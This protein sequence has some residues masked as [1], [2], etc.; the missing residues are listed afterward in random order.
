MEL[1][2]ILKIFIYVL[3]DLIPCLV[4]ALIPFQNHFR[5]PGYKTYMLLPLLFSMVFISRILSV[6]ELSVARWFTIL[7]IGLYLTLYIVCIKVPVTI[8]LFTLLTILNYGSFKA[9]IVNWLVHSLP[10]LSAGRYSFF[11]SI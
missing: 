5:F 1:T 3:L 11:S 7:W 4:L 2:E 9:I 6:Q 8:L 10:V